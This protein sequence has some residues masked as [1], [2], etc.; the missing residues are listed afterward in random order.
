MWI[1]VSLSLWYTP[2]NAIAGSRGNS[3][4]WGTARLFQSSGTIL[5]ILMTLVK[6]VV[7]SREVHD[8]VSLLFTLILPP[9]K[10]WQLQDF[11]GGLVVRTQLSLPRPRFNPWSCDPD[12]K[13]KKTVKIKML[14]IH[15]LTTPERQE[16]SYPLYR[17]GDWSSKR[18]TLSPVHPGVRVRF[19]IQR[20][21]NSNTDSAIS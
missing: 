3:N 2:R 18:K 6:H 10:N 19:W 14:S 21:V 13:T 8:Q 1:C 16:K 20:D 17:W 15:P 4:Y 7:I 5:H 9:F 12:K 11:P